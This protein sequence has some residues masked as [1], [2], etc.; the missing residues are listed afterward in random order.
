MPKLSNVGS[1][2]SFRQVSGDAGEADGGDVVTGRLAEDQGQIAG[3]PGDTGGEAGQ[4]ALV[5]VALVQ[6]AAYKEVAI[7]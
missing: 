3:R 4:V 6:L 1:D 5:Q 2:D 7:F